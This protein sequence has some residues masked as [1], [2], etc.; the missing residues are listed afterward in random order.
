MEGFWLNSIPIEAHKKT[1]RE[2][3]KS[4]AR[5]ALKALGNPLYN[6]LI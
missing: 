1:V 2:V 6:F 5:L 4:K 3:N